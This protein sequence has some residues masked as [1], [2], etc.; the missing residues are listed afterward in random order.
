[1]TINQTRGWML[2]V[3]SLPKRA[4]NRAV[5]VPAE[6]DIQFFHIFHPI[7]VY[8]H[9]FI[10]NCI[11][12]AKQN[13]EKREKSGCTGHSSQKMKQSGVGRRAEEWGHTECG[14]PPQASR[15]PT[16][17][18]LQRLMPVSGRKRSK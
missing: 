9:H 12:N 17:D 1:M 2:W 11:Q 8:L 4:R 3:V 18:E 6:I 5:L 16:M 15:Y 7:H 10:R 14:A 13:Q